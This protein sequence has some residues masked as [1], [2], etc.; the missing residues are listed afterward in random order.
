MSA[1]S[2]LICLAAALPTFADREAVEL[3]YTGTLVPAGRGAARVPVKKFSVYCLATGDRRRASLSYVIEEEG[4]GGWA[5]PERYGRIALRVSFQPA[6]GTRIR[7]LHTHQGTKYPLTVQQPLFEFFQQLQSRDAWKDGKLRYSVVG[8]R[9]LGDRNCRRIEIESRI[10]HR[11]T[12]WVAEGSPI[13]VKSRQVVF[14]GRGDR[15][16][17]QMDLTSAKTV[18]GDRH[19]KLRKV[20]TALLSLKTKLNRRENLTRPAL[21]AAQLAHVKTALPTL[22]AD[23]KATPF[24]PLVAFMKGDVKA[25]GRREDDV[26]NLAAKFVGRKAPQITLKDLRGRVVDPKERDG[27]ITVLHFWKYRDKPLAEPYG[28]VGYLDYLNGK[29][30]KLGVKVYGVAVDARLADKTT[31]APA[32][33]SIRK[34]KN[35]MN[36]GYTVTQDDGALLKKFGDPRKYDA[37]LPLWVVIDS[38]GIVRHYKTGFYQVQPREGLKPL[39]AVLIRLIRAARGQ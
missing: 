25:Q 30:A 33:R 7:L 29:R 38:K 39:D 6:D 16:H 15:F 23:A 1:S 20:S 34:L 17:L 9:K 11:Q 37:K 12:L 19:A 32:L 21:S 10:G 24:A 31:S 22:E 13:V 14:M 35:F 18:S 3:Q 2:L 4:G 5:W 36:L 8:S 28:Q 26:A 27:K